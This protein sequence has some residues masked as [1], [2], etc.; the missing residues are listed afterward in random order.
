M[1][2][3]GRRA[4][5]APSPSEGSAAGRGCDPKPSAGAVLEGGRLTPAFVLPSPGGSEG[6]GVRVRAVQPGA[7]QVTAHQAPGP[8]PLLPGA[9][10]PAWCQ[11]PAGGRLC[12]LLPLPA[13]GW[14]QT[15]ALPAAPWVPAAAPTSPVCSGGLPSTDCALLRARPGPGSVMEQPSSLL[16]ALPPPPGRGRAAS[17]SVLPFPS[18]VRGGVTAF[19]IKS[20]LCL[21]SQEP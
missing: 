4:A 13:R 8:L 20:E 5:C 16:L 1:S 21:R 2:G 7:H 15:Q 3:R 6:D 9:R 11:R 10:F 18:A 19:G 14:G 17:G 12:S